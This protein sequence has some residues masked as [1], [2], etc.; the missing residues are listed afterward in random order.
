[1]DE[2]LNEEL[3]ELK[4]ILEDAPE[5]NIHNFDIDDVEK[6]NDSMI[7]AYKKIEYI[8]LEIVKCV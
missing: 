3:K 5:I 6:L 7:S 1:M 4:D 2:Q 8:L